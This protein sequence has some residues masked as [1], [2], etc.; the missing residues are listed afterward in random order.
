MVVFLRNDGAQQGSVLRWT[1]LRTRIM[2]VPVMWVGSVGKSKILVYGDVLS[3][4]SQQMYYVMVKV[5]ELL[6][7]YHPMAI[8][9]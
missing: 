3:C 5:R 1:S 8:G 2:W 6:T 4:S 7:L 9:V